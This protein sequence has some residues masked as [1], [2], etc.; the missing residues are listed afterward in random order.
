LRIPAEN[1]VSASGRAW[2]LFSKDTWDLESIN[3]VEWAL[4]LV[5]GAKWFLILVGDRVY[6]V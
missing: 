6:A 3:L 1:A 2:A 4:I 5:P